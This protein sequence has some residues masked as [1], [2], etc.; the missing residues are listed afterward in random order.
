MVVV[1]AR[2]TATADDGRP[3]TTSQ[4]DHHGL[5]GDVETVTPGAFNKEGTAPRSGHAGVEAR[6]AQTEDLVHAS[7]AQAEFG[8]SSGSRGR[9]GSPAPPR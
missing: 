3:R 8:A 7:A 9:A 2:G 6:Q 5:R 1:D 4:T